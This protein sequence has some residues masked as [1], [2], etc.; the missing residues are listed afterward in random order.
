MHIITQE[1][2]EEIIKLKK[3]VQITTNIH[4]LMLDRYVSNL[5]TSDAIT[6]DFLLQLDYENII[7]FGAFEDMMSDGQ[8]LIEWFLLYKRIIFYGAS[9]HY[10]LSERVLFNKLLN[11]LVYKLWSTENQIIILDFTNHNPVTEFGSASNVGKTSTIMSDYKI[12]IT[13]G[14]EPDKLLIYHGAN[15]NDFTIN[16]METNGVIYETEF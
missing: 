9:Q 1:V 12:H 15:N 8:A 5:F 10:E 3:F 14:N 6:L 2:L 4:S 11:V 16:E 7:T 13:P